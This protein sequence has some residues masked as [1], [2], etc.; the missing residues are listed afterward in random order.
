MVR[1]I[2]SEEQAARVFEAI[3]LAGK[4]DT[5]G[6]G[7]M[8]MSDLDH[9]ATYIPVSCHPYTEDGLTRRAMLIEIGTMTS[10][11]SGQAVYEALKDDDKVA[12][13]FLETGRSDNLFDDKQFGEFGEAAILSIIVDEKD[14][15]A[16][17]EKVF[18]ISGL[19][20]K[21]CGYGL[22]WKEN[23]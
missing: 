15:D 3:Y 8:Y 11:K 2:V 21:E 16:V 9:V 14:H 10:L 4:L 17:F 19:H 1:I 22:C 18:N 6:K 23:Y 20:E 7:I 5:P 13:V 12:Y